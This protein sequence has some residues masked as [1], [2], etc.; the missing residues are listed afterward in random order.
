MLNRAP[1][2]LEVLFWSRV[3]NP[4]AGSDH[5]KR[6]I[7]QGK[8]RFPN[9]A[10]ALRPFFGVVFRLEQVIR[11]IMTQHERNPN[12]QP[13]S[14]GEGVAVCRAVTATAFMESRG[15]ALN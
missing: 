4:F 10:E 7:G 13:S 3:L 11:P 5:D 8:R 15:S 9:A 1:P 6:L 12:T 14:R 2:G